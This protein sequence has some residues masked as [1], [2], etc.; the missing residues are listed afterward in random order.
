GSGRWCSRSTDGRH[1][2]RDR[3]RRRARD[4]W[5]CVRRS[6]D[7]SADRDGVHLGPRCRGDR[8]VVRG[9]EGQV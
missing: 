7:R 8:L 9:K 4:R 3:H 6:G 5:P 2:R 1:C